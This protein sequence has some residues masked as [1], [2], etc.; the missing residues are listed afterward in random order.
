MKSSAGP[1][2]MT[3]PISYFMRWILTAGW[4]G[5]AIAPTMAILGREVTLRRF[6]GIRQVILAGVA[7]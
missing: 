4:S 3:D 7:K 1:E 2:A 5:P 6:A